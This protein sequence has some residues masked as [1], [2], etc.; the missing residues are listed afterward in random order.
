MGMARGEMRDDRGTGGP[1]GDPVDALAIAV[2]AAYAEHAGAL[3]AY[4]ASRTRDIAAAEDLVHETFLRLLTES[5]E[6]R[7]PAH[8]RAWLFRVATNLATSRARRLRVASRRAPELVV[9][10]VAA[11]PEEE[12]IDR[13]A[14]GAL[15]GRLTGLPAHVREALLLTAAGFS[16]A[17]VAR[18][19]GR[20]ELATR[21]LL[22]RYRSRLRDGVAA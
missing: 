8:L 2:S 14:A 1:A 4:L 10:E 17:E 9:R 20:S 16:G 19:I 6:S 18:R 7:A 3:R 5:A 12:L 15:R 11:S 21:S 22:C 13:E